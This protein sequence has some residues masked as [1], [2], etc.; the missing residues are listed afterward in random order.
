MI[1]QEKILFVDDDPAVLQGYQRLLHDSFRVDTAVGCKGAAISLTFKG[2]Y[3]V[4]VSD[5]RMPEMDGLAVFAQARKI[6]PA[7]VR[8]LLTGKT[9]LDSAMSAI[10]DSN[11]FRF[12][13]KPCPK[14]KFSAVLT[15]AI[16]QY[17][18]LT[19]EKDIVEKTFL[20]IIHVLTDVLGLVNPA[21]FSRA[22]RLRR[23]VTGMADAVGLKE[24]W[25][26]EVA[27]MMSQLG[28]VTLDS[29]LITA[30]HK[31]ASL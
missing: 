8:I 24:P 21:A 28:C 1:T 5:M 13:T 4:V 18:L 2:P 12:L 6:S 17:R 10:N 19:T 9:A 31:G 14:E 3:A 23:Y 26:V 30:V 15:A 27:A 11:I 29:E 25:K 20:E 16:H 22:V 7:T